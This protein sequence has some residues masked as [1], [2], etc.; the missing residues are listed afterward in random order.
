MRPEIAVARCSAKA[1]PPQYAQALRW[2]YFTMRRLWL[3]GE[4]VDSGRSTV[5]GGTGSVADVDMSESGGSGGT[6]ATEDL[7]HGLCGLPHDSQRQSVVGRQ[8]PSS[9]VRLIVGFPRG[10]PLDIVARTVAP[11]LSNR[12]GEEVVVH[13]RPGASGN[14][15]TAEVVSAAPDGHTLLLCGPVNTINSTLFEHLDFDFSCDI[16]PVGSIARVPL[17][18]EVHRRFPA[19]SLSEFLAFTREHPGRVKVAFAGVGTP[20]HVAIKRFEKM[21]GVM[22]RPVA[23]SGSEAA[24][25][26]L[27][28][29][30]ADVMF[31]PAPSSMPHIMGARLRAL[32]TTG[33]TRSSALPDVPAVAE[34]VP[35]YEAGSWFGIGAPALTPGRIVERLNTALNG[36]LE[37]LALIEQ[38]RQIGATVMTGTPSAF[39]RF[40]ASETDSFRRLIRYAGITPT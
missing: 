11:V 20:Q 2:C 13:N 6:M 10:G 12:L 35:H 24:L 7:A 26:D 40:I 22:F 39:G 29:G 17:L 34:L 28:G 14:N 18:V 27:L 25:S 19:R 5:V 31:D 8:Y 36:C 33:P 38:F 15:A 9:P 21:A 32:A 1:R 16:A 37:E 30:D 4:I 23:Y 3:P